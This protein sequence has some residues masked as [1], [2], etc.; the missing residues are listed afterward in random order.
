MKMTSTLM[1]GLMAAA[2]LSN[3]ADAAPVPNGGGAGYHAQ[4]FYDGQRYAGIYPQT[5]WNECNQ[6]L[7]TRI[8]YDTTHN[9]YHVVKVVPCHY[10]GGPHSGEDEYD[11]RQDYDLSI[12]APTPEASATLSAELLGQIRQLRETYRMDAYEQAL[13]V[14]RDAAAK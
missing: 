3:T 9:G 7:N 8:Q 11:H 6:M 1:L 12:S 5:T 10:C 14:I 13:G 4:V 2:V